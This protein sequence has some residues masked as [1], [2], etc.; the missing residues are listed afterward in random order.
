MLLLK[1][2]IS[3][4][5]STALSSTILFA[6]DKY[7]PHGDRSLLEHRLYLSIPF[8]INNKARPKHHIKYGYSFNM[9]HSYLTSSRQRIL[10]RDFKAA[11]INIQ[12]LPSRENTINLAGIPLFQFNRTGIYLDEEIESDGDTTNLVLIGV[13]T[14]GVLALAVATSGEEEEPPCDPAT[15]NGVPII[16]AGI[17]VC[18]SSDL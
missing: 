9:K 12:F 18:K 3:F 2:V 10:R 16:F 1:Y 15:I 14:L 4:I 7:F 8:S 17:P 11:L 5:L 6:E 13:G